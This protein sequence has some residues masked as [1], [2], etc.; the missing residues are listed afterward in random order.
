MLACSSLI[1]IY[2]W[3]QEQSRF[4][5]FVI[6]ITIDVVVIDV[7]IMFNISKLDFMFAIIISLSQPR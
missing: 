5:I 3:R 1:G 2:F 4:T 6:F 7:I